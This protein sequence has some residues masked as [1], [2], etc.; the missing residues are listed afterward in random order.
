MSRKKYITLNIAALIISGI[1]ILSIIS[2]LKG[3][4]NPEIIE[5]ITTVRSSPITPSPTPTRSNQEVQISFGDKI[6]IK[7]EESDTENFLFQEAKNRGVE[8]MAVGNYTEAVAE[9]Q[10]ALQNYRNAPETLIYLNN[11]RIGDNK[12]YTI[13]IAVP[14]SDDADSVLKMLRGIAQAQ[15]EI[16]Q[17]GGINTVP[18]K[19]VITDDAGKPEIA[20]QVASTLT[21]N[22]DIIAVVGHHSS[23]TTLA[24]REIYDS[25]KLV[26]ISSTSTSVEL[27]EASTISPT[28]RYVFRTVPNDSIAAKALANY[29]LTQLKKRKVAVFYDPKSR[30]SKSLKKEFIG[31]VIQNQGEVVEEFE[32][33]ESD[34]DFDAYNY[35]KRAIDR[36]AELLM[37]AAPYDKLKQTLSIINVNDNRLQLLGGDDIYD[38]RILQEG[39]SRATGIVIA[40]AWHIDANLNSAFV[41]KSRKLW[42][43]D[44]DWKTAM[45]YDASQALIAALKRNPTRSGVQEALTSSDF[46]T[47]GVSDTIRFVNSGDRLGKVQLVKVEKIPEGKTSRS[48]TGFDFVPLGK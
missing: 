20:K 47:S 18:L 16:N 46:K 44:V 39:R 4:G 23:G 33:S 10:K 48:R 28:K 38:I 19:V 24:A 11:A 36:N 43:A 8:A 21:K 2:L 5:K 27:S 9:F 30:Y 6:L 29:M 22:Q 26:A 41:S 14:I 32:F 7:K 17:M 3:Y 12:S 15:D 35:V 45:T 13:A 1:F 37:L 31:E 42:N 40:M 25:Q 34:R